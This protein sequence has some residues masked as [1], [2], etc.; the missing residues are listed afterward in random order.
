M[1]RSAGCC[2]TGRGDG[3]GGT[4]RVT[5]KARC[6]RDGADSRCIRAL[7]RFGWSCSTSVRPN[8][9]KRA[10]RRPAAPLYPI[11]G[12]TQELYR[13]LDSEGGFRCSTTRFRRSS[14]RLRRPVRSLTPASGRWRQRD[15]RDRRHGLERRHGLDPMSANARSRRPRRP[16]AASF[17]PVPASMRWWGRPRGVSA[18]AHLGD[19]RRPGAQGCDAESSRVHVSAAATEGG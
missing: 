16:P 10:P 4:S 15:A 1:P 5:T 7:L 2:H 6:S 13:H 12:R 17:R 18:R 8:A 14:W 9:C 3:G 11:S 19:D